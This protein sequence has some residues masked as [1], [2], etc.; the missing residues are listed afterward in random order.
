MHNLDEAENTCQNQKYLN[1]IK[2]ANPTIS[3]VAC[4]YTIFS[5]LFTYI[6]LFLN[7]FFSLLYFTLLIL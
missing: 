4:F 1:I 7:A 5:I 2:H 3:G 6:F